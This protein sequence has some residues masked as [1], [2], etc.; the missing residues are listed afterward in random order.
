VGS[1]IAWERVWDEFRDATGRRRPDLIH[2]NDTDVGLGSRRDRHQ[3]IGYGQI[4]SDGFARIVRDPRLRSVPM[5]LETPKGP[6]EVTWDR[7]ALEL[8]R[9][10]A[11][12]MPG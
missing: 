5:V 3:R 11:S 1:E 2:L 10:L 6:D 8:L 7:E 12:A 4:G 9:G